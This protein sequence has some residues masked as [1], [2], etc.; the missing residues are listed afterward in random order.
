MK[1][2]VVGGRD[3]AKYSIANVVWEKITS[4]TNHELVFRFFP[5]ESK[6]E[7]LQFYSMFSEDVDFLGFN[8]AVPWK[9]EIATLVGRTESHI[10]LTAMNTIYKTKE[11]IFSANTDVIGMEQILKKFAGDLSHKK[12]LILGAGGAGLSCAV[13]L[14]QKHDCKVYIHEIN[15]QIII[16]QEI[17]AVPN[18]NLSSQAGK[19]DIIINATPVGKYYLNH[20]PV[21][22][23]SPISSDILAK[24]VHQ[25]TVLNE[26]L[27]RSPS[28]LKR[29][30]LYRELLILYGEDYINSLQF[31]VKEQETESDLIFQKEFDLR[32]EYLQRH[33]KENIRQFTL[34]REEHEKMFPNFLK[35]IVGKLQAGFPKDRI[36]L[37]YP[38][39]MELKAI[40]DRSSGIVREID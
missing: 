7:L 17:V 35:F 31:Q 40:V 2:G 15:Q 26:A 6:D 34:S 5:I 37:V 24:I 28:A 25:D 13:Y 9:E 32:K 3:I 22:P 29:I 4:A 36:K 39:P 23:E 16:P 1:I 27:S 38:Q 20:I 30:L 14:T 12:I 21:K 33:A 18:L 8:V 10:G 11:G 19:F